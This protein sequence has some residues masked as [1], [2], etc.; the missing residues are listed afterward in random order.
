MGLS[1]P[2]TELH[3]RADRTV[4]V[5]RRSDCSHGP[6]AV[7]A[8]ERLAGELRIAIRVEDVVI[9]ADD[10]ARTQRCLGSPTVLVAGQDVEPAA[11][12]RSAFAAT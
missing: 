1:R 4:T 10:D 12:G 9:H 11:R 5:V 7:E 2:M 6:F 8:V 3:A